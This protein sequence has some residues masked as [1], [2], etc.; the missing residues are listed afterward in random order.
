[1]NKRALR[2]GR[3]AA[4]DMDRV[5]RVVSDSEES[6][7]GDAQETLESLVT[8]GSRELVAYQNERYAQRYRSMVEKVAS[9]ERHLFEDTPLAETVARYAFKVMAYKDEYEV[10]RLYTDGSFERQVAEEFEGDYRVHLH[11]APQMLPVNPLT[12]RPQK[13]KLGRWFLKVLAL[14]AK[15]R[16]LRGTPLDP[17]QLMAHRRLEKQLVDDYESLVDILAS[18]LAPDSRDVAIELASLPEHV[19]GFDDIKEDNL[20]AALSKQSELVESFRRLAASS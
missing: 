18:G 11:L 6:G 8:D 13:L 12:G 7:E 20:Q 14:M 15:L 10:A 9:A 16:F 17:T 3:L 4:H 5:R 2:W 19:R 1:M